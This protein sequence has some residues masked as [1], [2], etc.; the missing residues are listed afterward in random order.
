MIAVAP[1]RDIRWAG[2]ESVVKNKRVEVT[3]PDGSKAIGKAT[4]VDPDTIF[5]TE[6][7]GERKIPR[8]GVKEINVI[9]KGKAYRTLFLIWGASV[10]LGGVVE[11][12]GKGIAGGIGIG[13][14]GYVLGDYL[15]HRKT[16][17]TIIE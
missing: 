6:A 5:L 7:S 17:L 8:V 14:G 2:L 1:A 13:A 9:R 4:R 3:L 11:G 16:L 12:G 10:V 15:D